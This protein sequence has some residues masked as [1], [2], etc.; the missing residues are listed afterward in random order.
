MGNL[1]PKTLTRGVDSFY[2]E[3]EEKEEEKEKEKGKAR[4]RAQ[5][6]ADDRKSQRWLKMWAPTADPHFGRFVANEDQEII[7]KVPI[8][9]R[10]DHTYDPRNKHLAALR[11]RGGGGKKSK[12]RT[13]KNKKSK[14]RTYKNKKSKKSRTKKKRSRKR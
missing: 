12:K 3:T 11:A 6:Q 4:T 7:G 9:M 8:L 10:E 13:Y 14:K 2:E 1:L 5:A